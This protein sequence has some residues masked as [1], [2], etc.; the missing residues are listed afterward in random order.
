MIKKSSKIYI[1]GHNGLVGSELLSL[2][3]RKWV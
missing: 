3:I 2:L 1:A